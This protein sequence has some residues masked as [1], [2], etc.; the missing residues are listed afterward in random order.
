MSTN[1]TSPAQVTGE[2]ISQPGVTEPG[3]VHPSGAQPGVGGPPAAPPDAA[4]TPDG[5]TAKDSRDPTSGSSA[6]GDTTSDQGAAVPSII[7]LPVLKGLILYG[8]ILAFAGLYIYFIVRISGAKAGTPPALDAA[9]VSAAAVLAGILGSAFALE[10][11]VPPDGSSTNRRLN[12]TLRNLKAANSTSRTQ[13]ASASI[14]TILSIDPPST[15]SPS[16]PKTVGTW[17]YAAIASAVTI[18]YVLNQPETPGTI[19]TLAIAFGGYVV[20]FLRGVY[21]GSG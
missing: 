17:T 21:K 8:A 6:G 18:T 7:G 3:A 19:K 16:W 13:R 9:L 10:I 1:F 14:Q 20:A 11:G 5:A 4:L 15:E 2:P 12:E